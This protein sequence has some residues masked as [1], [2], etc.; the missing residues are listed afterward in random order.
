M[1]FLAIGSRTPPIYLIC[2]GGVSS[3]SLCVSFPPSRYASRPGVSLGASVSSLATLV[4]A[5]LALSLAVRFRFRHHRN[6]HASPCIHRLIIRLLS[7]QANRRT[8]NRKTDE[9]R[10]NEEQENKRDDK[11]KHELRY[12]AINHLITF[13]PDP[14]LRAL[15]RLRSSYI[16]PPPGRRD[17]RTEAG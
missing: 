14:L 1:S 16:P 12:R 5:F 8:R 6:H 10:T 17:E 13:S 3:F 7:H 15:P 9:E 11:A 2:S 4:S